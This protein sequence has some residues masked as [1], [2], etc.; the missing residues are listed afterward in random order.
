MIFKDWLRIVGLGFGVWGLG[1]GGWGL[2]ENL[3]GRDFD[4]H[5]H[6]RTHWHACS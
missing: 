2:E 1:V 3:D 6:A 4:L 5:E